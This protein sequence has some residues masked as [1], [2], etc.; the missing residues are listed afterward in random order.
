VILHF[1][2]IDVIKRNWLKRSLVPDERQ[3]TVLASL[4]LGNAADTS[5][6]FEDCWTAVVADN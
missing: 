6:A 1:P 2:V 5:R 3:S 4:I